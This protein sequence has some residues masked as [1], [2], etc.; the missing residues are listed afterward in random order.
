MLNTTTIQGFKSAAKNLR[1]ILT[2]Y[3]SKISHTSSLET[4]S[5]ILGVK[6]YNIIKN[7]LVENDNTL[8]KL[9]KSIKEMQEMI[10][11]SDDKLSLLSQKVYGIEY[12]IQD[13][14]DE[15]REMRDE[16]NFYLCFSIE[17]KTVSNC[18]IKVEKKWSG[19]VKNIR[20]DKGFYWV[21][22]TIS[23]VYKDGVLVEYK[24]IRVPISN[25]EKLNSQ[26]EYDNL[27]SQNNEKTRHIV[28]K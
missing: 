24:S 2:E 27:K 23:G 21:N 22:A 11:I 7:E 25:K 9:S 5:K 19:N 10:K 1:K 12:T 17:N 20:K 18:T 15:Y 4:L 13:L 26:K 6:N 3:D 8:N 14:N 16:N 28:Y